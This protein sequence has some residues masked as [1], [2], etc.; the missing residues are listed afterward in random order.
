M[1][2]LLEEPSERRCLIYITDISYNIVRQS[3]NLFPK[4]YGE[5]STTS[6]AC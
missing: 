2:W 6:R 4:T 1:F 5:E 3:R